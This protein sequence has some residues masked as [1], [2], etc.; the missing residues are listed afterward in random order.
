VPFQFV[1]DRE[2]SHHDGANRWIVRIHRAL[3]TGLLIFSTTFSTASVK[4]L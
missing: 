2:P 1:R 3:S 4:I